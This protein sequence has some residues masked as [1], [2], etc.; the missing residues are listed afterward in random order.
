[1]TQQELEAFFKIVEIG[2]ISTAAKAMYITQPAMSRRIKNL[3]DQ[4]GYT[5]F[6]RNKGKKTIELSSKGKEFQPIAKEILNNIKKAV[7]LKDKDEKK[8]LHISSIGS[9]SNYLLPTILKEFSNEYPSIQLFFNHSHSY[10]AYSQ[11]NEDK[12]DL[13]IISDAMY[14]K[15]I[16]TI[17]LF[18]EDWYFVSKDSRQKSVHPSSLEIDKEIYIPWSPEF[19]AWHD[20]WFQSNTNYGVSLDQMS[21]LEYFLSFD[22]YWAIVPCSIANRIKNVRLSKVED[23]PSK[24]IIYYLQKSGI[25]NESNTLFIQTMKK[26]LANNPYLCLY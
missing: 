2:N 20:Y 1:M 16:E 23:G 9:V 4:L 11:I 17:P 13:A 14:M 12:I 3:E 5:L 8:I 25:N 19:K 6:I 21:L 24:R 22:S 15:N 26:S 10:E 7:E 18:E